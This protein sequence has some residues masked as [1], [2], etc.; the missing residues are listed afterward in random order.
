MLYALDR[1]DI[2]YIL[3]GGVACV[4]HGVEQT[5]YDTDVLPALDEQNL[6]RLLAALGS[7]DAGVFVDEARLEMESGDLWETES[8]RRGAAGIHYE[9]GSAPPP[10]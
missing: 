5:T 10:S 7:L 6:A 9:A 2:T 3:I 4:M 1:A 8:L